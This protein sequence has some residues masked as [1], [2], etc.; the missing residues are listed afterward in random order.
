[1]TD[2][3]W[4]ALWCRVVVSSIAIVGFCV[5]LMYGVRALAAMNQAPDSPP[6]AS[7]T[8]VDDEEAR[9]WAIIASGDARGR[10][11]AAMAT[12]ID[13]RFLEWRARR[14]ALRE[15]GPLMAAHRAGVAPT[16]S[17]IPR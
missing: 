4:V 9:A 2:V 5:A 1:M 16:Y 3:K 11:V 8:F 14:A 6:A 12:D 17:E 15:F 7:I 10:S 13:A